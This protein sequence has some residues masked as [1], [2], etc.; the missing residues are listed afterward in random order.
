[1]AIDAAVLD[2]APPPSP[3]PVTLPEDEPLPLEPSPPLEL[4]LAPLD[5][6]VAPP[7]LLEPQATKTIAKTPR[8][9]RDAI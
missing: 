6:A 8:P 3:E 9:R 4:L 7:P 2:P 1:M 5:V